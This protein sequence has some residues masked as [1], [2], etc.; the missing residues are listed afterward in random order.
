M[1]IVHACTV[2][3]LS[4]LPETKGKGMGVLDNDNNEETSPE[5]LL[6]D[7]AEECDSVEL[8]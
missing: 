8:A 7:G 3:S 6:E 4:K 1:L 5:R 2:I